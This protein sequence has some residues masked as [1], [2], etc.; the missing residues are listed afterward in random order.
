[1]K[2]RETIKWRIFPRSTDGRVVMENLHQLAKVGQPYTLGYD[3]PYKLRCVEYNPEIGPLSIVMTFDPVT[4][5]DSRGCEVLFSDFVL[6]VPPDI[7]FP[8]YRIFEQMRGI[9]RGEEYK[10][11]DQILQMVYEVNNMIGDKKYR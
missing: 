3:G 5:Y 11:S 10:K 6:I 1:M 9:S 4:L 8:L 7:Q 2:K